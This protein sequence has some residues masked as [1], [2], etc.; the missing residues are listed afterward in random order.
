MVVQV[1]WK[2]LEAHIYLSELLD[3]KVD[4][5]TVFS[6]IQPIAVCLAEEVN[7]SILRCDENLSAF[8]C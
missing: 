6:W 1:E 7:C 8:H 5:Y 3:E 4:R 2:P